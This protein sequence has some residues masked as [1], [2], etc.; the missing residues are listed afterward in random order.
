MTDNTHISPSAADA[1]PEGGL[2]IFQIDPVTRF[3]NY[4]SSISSG[5]NPGCLGV[6]TDGSVAV[7]NVP[8]NNITGLVPDQA[9]V[10]SKPSLCSCLRGR[11]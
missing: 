4:Q 1:G 9:I 10:R 6:L 11:L 8:N 3:L 5:G 7:A 2:A